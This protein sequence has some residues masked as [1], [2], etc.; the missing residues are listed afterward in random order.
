MKIGIIKE[1]KVPQDKRVP[2]TPLE[3][4]ELLEKFPQVELFVQPSNIRT[5]KDS[6]YSDLGKA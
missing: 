2:L 6:E 1:G 3:C 4:K 5:F